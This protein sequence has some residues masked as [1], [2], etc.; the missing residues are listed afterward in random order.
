MSKKYSNLTSL[1][2]N[3]VDNR[4]KSVPVSDTGFP[5]IATNCIKHSSIYPTF[6]NIRYVNDDIKNNW[7]RTHPE[8]NDIIF[9]NKGT[10]GRVCLVP[11]PVSFCFAQDMIGFR[12]DPE[13]IDYQYLFAI[14]RSEYIQK[15]I[16]NYHV[17]LV[18]PHFK[19]GD[20]DSLNIPRMASRAEELAI[21]ELYLTLSKK[22]E[23]NNLINTEL[24]AM[25]KTLYDYWFVQFD[26]PNEEGK[27]YKSSGGKMV[28]NSILKREIPEGWSVDRLQSY[29]NF[30]RGISYKSNEISHIQGKEFLNLNSFSLK[31]EFKIEGTKYFIGK[32]NQESLV[33][34][35][36]L[37]VAITDVT[38]NADII[39]KAFIIPNI[40]ED[41]ALISCDVVS[42]TSERLNKFY[43]EQLFNSTYYHSYIKYY[44][45]GTLV[46]HL[47]LNGINWFNAILPPVGLLNQFEEF[48]KPILK[49]K[50][51]ILKENKQLIE[52]RDWLLPML[53]NGQV[54]VK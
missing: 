23:L 9:V 21:G 32:Y 48:C 18:I 24:E 34:S 22:I 28:Y 30:K 42:V 19:K 54:T 53:M 13:K 38:R 7:F 20:L 17:G 29:I 25:A 2:A 10:P 35:G 15:K 4:G 1:L 36:G 46:L 49:K 16:E 52:L 50:A 26:F 8:P 45:S 31:G 47:N 41:G 33:S 12:C 3:I 11:D 5:L 27:P 14:L 43:L 37:V 51:V 44:A 6:E 40:F 39:G